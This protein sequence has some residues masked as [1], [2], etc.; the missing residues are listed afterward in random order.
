MSDEVDEGV[1]VTWFVESG[2]AVD[3]GALVASVQVEKVEEEVYAPVG[4]QV[5]E[6]VVGQGDVV[7]QGAVI[8]RIGA[9]DEQAAAGRPAVVSGAGAAPPQPAP[10][11]TVA[12]ASPAARRVAREL[13]VDLAAV[14]G[15]G[16]GGRIVEDDVRRASE[17]PSAGE[18]LPGTRR[19]LADRV[20]NWLAATAQ[21][22]LT[23]EVDVTE[24]AQRQPQWTA[25]VVRAC[26]LAL[27]RHP[28]LASRWHGD[29]L[30]PPETFDIGVAVSLEDGLVVPVIHRADEKDLPTLASDVA[31][32]AERASAGTLTIDDVSGAVF[33][34]TNLGGHPIDAFTPL[35]YQPQTA[36]LGVGRARARPAVVDDRIEPR[37]TLVL[38]LTVDHQVTDGAPA[39]AFL[40]DIADLL[41]HPERLD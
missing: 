3:E 30:V 34:V 22:T 23:S 38:S 1:L 24:L 35:V 33:T 9:A 2:A 26:V 16:P 31:A 17:G 32:L 36:I 28:R 10:A 4:G 20:R 6:L 18:P 27:P 19:L 21:F 7:Q 39:A 40:A 13:G 25:A 15:T 11:A 12:L 5:L 41:A 8:A 14:Q 29:R 37:T